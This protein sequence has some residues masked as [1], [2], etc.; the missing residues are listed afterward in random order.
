MHHASVGYASACARTVGTL[1]AATHLVLERTY[2]SGTVP[3]QLGQPAD[4]TLLALEFNRL[5][6]TL[7]LQLGGACDRAASYALGPLT[8]SPLQDPDTDLLLPR[9]DTT[10]GPR[11]LQHADTPP[12]LRRTAATLRFRGNWALTTGGRTGLPVDLP[13]LSSHD[14]CAYARGTHDVVVG[15][16]GHGWPHAGEGTPQT[17]DGTM[18][19]DPSPRGDAPRASDWE[20]P[21][22]DR[23]IT[24]GP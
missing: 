19:R 12:A 9:S 2:L 20:D 11:G 24:W 23:R 17:L 6:G 22:V 5:S 13:D 7:P 18:F 4:L 15:A 14:M 21:H 8:S 3:P 1:T 16:A 10:D